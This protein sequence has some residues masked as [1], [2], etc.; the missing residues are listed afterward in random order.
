MF[1]VS[2]RNKNRNSDENTSRSFPLQFLKQKSGH[3]D[4]V[5]KVLKYYRYSV[6]STKYNEILNKDFIV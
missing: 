6:S 3:K 2:A 4:K 1:T 5:L